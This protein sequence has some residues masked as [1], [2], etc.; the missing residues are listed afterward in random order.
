[1]NWNKKQTE[2]IQGKIRE[3]F[4]EGKMTQQEIADQLHVSRAHVN[5]TIKKIRADI[6]AKKKKKAVV[7]SM[8]QRPMKQQTSMPTTEKQALTVLINKITEFCK[9]QN[10]ALEVLNQRLDALAKIPKKE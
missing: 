9:L 8:P 2:K 3:M 1:M 6:E 5:R 10:A 7:R 4:L